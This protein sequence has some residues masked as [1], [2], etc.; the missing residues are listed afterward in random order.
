MTAD[1]M[2]VE[3]TFNFTQTDGAKIL[4]MPYKGDRLSMLLILPDDRDGIDSLGDLLSVEKLRKWQNSMSATNVL[5]KIPKFTMKTHYELP[6]PLKDLGVEDIFDSK[7]ANLTGIL[8]GIFVSNAV[9]DAYVDVNEEGTEAAAVTT[10]VAAFTSGPPPT[11]LFVADH[12]FLF[13]IQD[14]ESGMIL[15][16]GKLSEPTAE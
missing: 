2:T 15:F 6:K 5:V 14:D 1:F 9:H 3:S 12:P 11:P 7:T 13:V 4:K 8:G 16:M 10:I